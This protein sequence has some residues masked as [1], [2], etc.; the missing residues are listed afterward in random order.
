MYEG[1]A[2]KEML[3]KRWRKDAEY[4]VRS[5]VGSNRP[6]LISSV[7]SPD[8]YM[9]DPYTRCKGLN[10]IAPQVNRHCS[11]QSMLLVNSH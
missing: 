6:T 10:E 7:C 1:L 9:Q 2:T 5:P 11:P 4:E 3:Q 8:G